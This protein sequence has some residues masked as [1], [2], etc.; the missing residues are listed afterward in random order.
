M[1]H[2]LDPLGVLGPE[3][4]IVRVVYGRPIIGLKN[5]RYLK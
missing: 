5:E 2:S 1:M 4:I 3:N